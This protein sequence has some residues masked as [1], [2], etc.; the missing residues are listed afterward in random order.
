MEGQWAALESFLLQELFNF[1]RR[2]WRALLG[3]WSRKACEN[4]NSFYFILENINI[5]CT[6]LS[7]RI[8]LDNPTQ[9]ENGTFQQFF[10]LA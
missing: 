2:I 8:I 4:I 3:G 1:S 9:G 10:T 5:Y 6:H 7:F